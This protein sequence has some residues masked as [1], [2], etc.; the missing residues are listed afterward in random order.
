MILEALSNITDPIRADIGSIN[1]FIAQRHDVP[2]NFRRLLST[3]LRNLKRNRRLTWGP[4]LL[5]DQ[6]TTFG[7]K[8]HTP[9]PKDR[10]TTQSENSTFPSSTLFTGQKI[11]EAENKSFVAHEAVKEAERVEVMAEQS[12]C[13]K[14]FFEDILEQWQPI[15]KVKSKNKLEGVSG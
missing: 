12:A 6:N 7:T 10:R 15:E 9:K 5:Q 8:A 1:D 3:K 13:T 11:A 2:S 4:K 14:L